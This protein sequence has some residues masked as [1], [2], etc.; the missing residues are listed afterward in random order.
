M[1]PAAA[2]TPSDFSSLADRPPKRKRITQDCRKR[3]SG[4][5]SRE[6]IPAGFFARR[7]GGV[8]QDFGVSAWTA[9]RQ[10][11]TRCDAPRRTAAAPCHWASG[12][13]HRRLAAVGFF[14]LTGGMDLGCGRDG[15]PVG[16]CTCPGVEPRLVRRAVDG[17]AE[18]GGRGATGN[19]AREMGKTRRFNI[20]ESP[21]RQIFP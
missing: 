12:F 3:A 16:F 21:S 8:E 4:N 10:G 6:K 5:P 18:R 11:E 20:L 9:R 14:L 7:R 1:K 15:G 13:L 17:Q 19:G 2:Q